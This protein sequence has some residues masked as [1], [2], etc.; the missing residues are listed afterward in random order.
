MGNKSHF[1]ILDYV[2]NL[3]GA[4]IE[5]GSSRGDGSTDFYAGLVY[6]LTQFNFYSV[7]FDAEQINHAKNLAIKIPNMKAFQL[8]GEDFLNNEF[9]QF[10]EKICYAYLDNFDWNYHES[11][12]SEPSWILDQRSRYT[13]YGLEYNNTNSAL[14]HLNQ[15]KLIVKHAAEKCLIQFDDTYYGHTSYKGKG[16]TAIPYLKDNG[17]RIVSDIEGSFILSNY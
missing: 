11:Q 9:P 1:L 4:I 15:T 10:N 13:E 2:K 12:F 6:G 3:S 17:W 5:I 7:D 14:A 16:M 8:L